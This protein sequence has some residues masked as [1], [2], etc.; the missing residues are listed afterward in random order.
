MTDLNAVFVKVCEHCKKQ[1][2]SVGYNL[3]ISMIRP[4]DMNNETVK[5]HVNSSFQKKVILDKYSTLLHSAFETVLGFPVKIEIENTAENSENKPKV[6]DLSFSNQLLQVE[7]EKQEAVINKYG[8]CFSNFVVGTSNKFAHAASL[9]VA[10]NPSGA[11]NPLFIYGASGLGKTHLLCAI[12]HEMTQNNPK[13]NILYAKG[14]EF[15]NELIEAIR[16]DSTKKFHDKYRKADVL[17]VD[18]IQFIAGKERTQEEFFHTFNELYQAGQQIVLTSDRPPKEIRTLEDRLRTRFE[19]GLIADVQPP[20]FET[21]IAIIQQKASVLGI[22]IPSEVVEYIANKIKNNNRQ[23]EGTVKKLQAY[24]ILAGTEPSIAIAQTIIRD[25]LTEEQPLELT[26]E[27]ILSEVSRTFGVSAADIKSQKR[28]A[29]ISKARQTAIYVA[30]TIL[31]LPMAV[32]GEHFGG[33]DHS[34]VL[35]ALSKMEKQLNYDSKLKEVVEDIIK[36]IKK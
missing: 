13:L 6:K 34:T 24:R 30:R 29:Q 16:C 32:I 21:R 15:T 25:I 18:D 9:A 36:N 33:R 23:L 11:Y 27:K 5:L 35:Y 4:I 8:Y 22:S 31:G 19:W 20:D 26:F 2:S 10:A 17:L 14:E 7:E 1:I 3:W 28:S 12:C